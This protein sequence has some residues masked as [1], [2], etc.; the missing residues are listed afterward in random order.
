MRTE[1]QT[2]KAKL[3]V[4]HRNFANAT[5]HMKIFVSFIFNSCLKILFFSLM[6]AEV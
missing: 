6:T 2:D 1:G 4:L 3:T 5:K